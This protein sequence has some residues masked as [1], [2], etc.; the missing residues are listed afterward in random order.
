[1]MKDLRVP[2]ELR[3]LFKKPWGK[4]YKGKGLGPAL[5]IKSEIAGENVIVVGDVTLRNITEVGIKPRLAIVD[6]KTKRENEVE[7]SGNA[8]VV[9]N[10][11]GT[12]SKELWEAIH[13]NIDKEG[14]TILVRGEED[15]AVLPCIL[16]ADWNTIILYGQP[17]EGIVLVRVNE[18]KKM[19]AGIV[20]KMLPAGA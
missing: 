14:V 6:L 8:V 1:M 2:A 3:G 17:N 16:E 12:I 4:L 13:E 9:N 5:K 11:P 10:P 7:F 15:L 18:D 19:R 20:L